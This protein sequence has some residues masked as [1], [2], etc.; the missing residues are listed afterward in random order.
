MS[1]CSA[2]HINLVFL[3]I[4]FEAFESLYVTGDF[5][6][7]STIIEIPLFRAR[8]FDDKLNTYHILVRFLIASGQASEGISKCLSV[9]GSLG[10]AV[11]E[12]VDNNI[13]TEEVEHVKRSLAD[14]SEDDLSGLPLMTD[15]RKLVRE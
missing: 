4:L 12:H 10:E 13:Y 3:P 6:T 14:L 5:E 9:L 7:L 8:C 2:L 15:G 11:P 1:I